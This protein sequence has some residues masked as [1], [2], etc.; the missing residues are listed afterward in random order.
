MLKGLSALLSPDLLHLLASMGL[1]DEIVLADASILLKK[2]VVQ[3]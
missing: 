2:G 1:G 3:S